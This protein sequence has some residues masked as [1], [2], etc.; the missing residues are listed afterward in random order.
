[1][2]AAV[3]SRATTGI[4]L[5]IQLLDRISPTRRPEKYR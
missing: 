5:S 4:A 3:A 2:T 1:M